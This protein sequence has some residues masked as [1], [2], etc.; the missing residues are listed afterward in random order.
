MQPNSQPTEQGNNKVQQKKRKLHKK[1]KN[2]Q[3]QK[4]HKKKEMNKI[5]IVYKQKHE[6]SL[7]IKTGRTTQCKKR[8][9]K[10]EVDGASGK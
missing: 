7:S 10:F 8:I 4:L 5:W 1:L 6:D 2:H 3:K 9:Q